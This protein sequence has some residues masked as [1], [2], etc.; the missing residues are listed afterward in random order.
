MLF[1]L[2][3]PLAFLLSP[4]FS[5]EASTGMDNLI[6]ASRN[7]RRKIVTAKLGA[8]AITALSVIGIYLAATFLFGFLSVGTLE[9]AMAAL[10]SVPAYVR[11][12]FGFL[13]WQFAAV[14]ALWVLLSGVTYALI[15]SFISSRMKSQVA[16]FGVSLIVLF[17][18]IGIAALG[19]GI[20]SMVRPIVDFGVANFA[21]VGEVFTQYKAYNI[22]G[23]PVPYH[24]MLIAFMAAVISLAAL[25]M[26]LGQKRR[27][28][29]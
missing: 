3:V 2:F 6:L 25:G 26:Y 10:R 23:F 12:P 7:G 16:A 18:N 15:V 11:A 9:G 1:V 13:N 19:T 20:E 8:V 29:A 21:L 4:V 17:L 14:S 28:V 5:I 22:F 27:T 24:A